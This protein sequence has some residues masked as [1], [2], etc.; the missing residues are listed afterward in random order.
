MYY[1]D[2]VWCVGRCR[3]QAGATSGARDA[4]PDGILAALDLPLLLPS[5]SGA[6]SCFEARIR[7]SL[8]G[9]H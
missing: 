7:A 9:R 3:M 8:L 2:H 5:S 4:L 1:A 6:R